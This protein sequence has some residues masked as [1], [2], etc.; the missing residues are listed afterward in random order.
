MPQYVNQ[1]PGRT[2]GRGARPG[3]QRGHRPQDGAHPQAQRPHQQGQRL[4]GGRPQE[5]E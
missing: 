1:V 5:C 2:R 4:A 3:D